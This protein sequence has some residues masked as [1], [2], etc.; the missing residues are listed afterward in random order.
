QAAISASD[1]AGA[2][3][4][5]TE[6]H[7]ASSMKTATGFEALEMPAEAVRR[8]DSWRRERTL[9]IDGALRSTIAAYR[10]GVASYRDELLLPELA[11]LRDRGQWQAAFSLVG[12][13]GEE[14]VR[15]AGFDPAHLPASELENVTVETRVRLDVELVALERDW[16]AEER[17]L[18]E[19]IDVE[20]GRRQRQQEYAT[21]GSAPK[22]S[23]L[24]GFERELDRRGQVRDQLPPGAWVDFRAAID[25]SDAELARSQ[26]SLDARRADDAFGLRSDLLVPALFAER[27]YEDAV[28]LWQSFLARGAGSDQELPA[29]AELEAA[30]RLSALLQRAADRVRAERGQVRELRVGN[31]RVAGRLDSGGDPLGDG[32]FLR[33]SQGEPYRLDLRSIDAGDLMA[34][35]GL[36]RVAEELDPDD[37]LAAA[38]LAYSERSGAEAQRILGSGAIP[39]GLAA[40]RL[41]ERLSAPRRAPAGGAELLERLEGSSGDG[42]TPLALVDP[43]A[44]E[45]LIDVLLER[46]LAEPEVGLRS[47]ALRRDLER[48]R[49]ARGS[50]DESLAELAAAFPRASAEL[51]DPRRARLAF[52]GSDAP[53]ERV[54]VALGAPLDL[55]GGSTVLELDLASQDSD[56]AKTLAVSV[57]GYR[58]TWRAADE[59]DRGRWWAGTTSEEP[60]AG[61]SGEVGRSPL[62][63][64]GPRTLRLEWDRPRASLRV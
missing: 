36:N 51:L 50:S 16:R 41:V 12:L 1:F 17:D 38:W 27:R 59:P 37:R 32:F 15:R 34:L 13:D 19:W 14:L 31:I 52:E 33:P 39:A 58:C 3:L 53:R 10:E 9:Q 61:A 49:R 43:Y 29:R 40:E 30:Q 5:V 2:R 44:A 7:M 35:T 56:G 25:R 47:T 20:A 21:A 42:A 62:S 26:A 55:E 6:E 11:R 48:L 18:R 63:A 22:E 57:A 23:L 28:V 4:L 24:E 46:H 8:I 64:A 45:V 60:F 54:E